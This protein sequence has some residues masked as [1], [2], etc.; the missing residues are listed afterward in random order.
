LEF[1]TSEVAMA[2]RKAALGKAAVFMYLFTWT[3]PAFDGL[4]RSSHGF[5]LPFTFD[6]LDMAPGLWAGQPPDPRGYE[7]AEKMSKA[8]ASFARTGDPSHPG[9]PQWKPY[10]AR[11]RWT[12]SLN[13]S[14]ELVDDP[15]GQDRIAATKYLLTR[16]WLTNT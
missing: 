16:G 8:W 13:Y 4:Y 1:R 14:C 10:T 7:L 9:L 11:E 2:E 3:C 5:D 15:R 12:M 6:N